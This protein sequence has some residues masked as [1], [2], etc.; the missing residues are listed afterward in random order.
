MEVLSD[1]QRIFSAP[2]T[3]GVLLCAASSTWERSGRDLCDVLAP[4]TRDIDSGSLFDAMFDAC[5]MIFG[6]L[7]GGGDRFWK[8]TLI[9]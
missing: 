5:L 9:L 7:F 2:A 3:F 1:S 8:E 6:Q 4:T